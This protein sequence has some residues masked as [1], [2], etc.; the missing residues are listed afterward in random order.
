M[1]KLTEKHD[2]ILD[3]LRDRL[4]DGLDE[5]ST[6]PEVL[7]DAMNTTWD[8]LAMIQPEEIA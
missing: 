5:D 1:R 2:R 8:A 6:W 4:N 3:E 7:E